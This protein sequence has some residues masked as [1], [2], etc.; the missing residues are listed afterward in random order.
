MR[1]VQGGGWRRAV[2][3]VCL[4]LLVVLAYG[5]ALHNGYVWDDRYF[6]TDY[7]TVSNYREAIEVAFAPLF[8]QGPYLRP[9]PLLMIYTEALASGFNP[10][11][12]HLANLLVHFVCSVLV[13]L[14]ALRASP[15]TRVSRTVHWV[16]LALAAAF[17]VHPALSEDVVWIS[18]RFDLLA[19]LF[20]LL[21][22]WVSARDELRDI[23]RALL[24]GALFLL[25]ALCKE[26][27]VVFP[28]LLAGYTLLRRASD[29]G[30][31]RIQLSAAFSRREWM[32]YAALLASGSLYLVLRASLMVG[33]S[34]PG[35][36][37]VTVEEQVVRV[38]LSLFKYAK[39]TFLPFVG[40]SPHHSFRWLE[41]S[42]W[43]Q[44]LLP[45]F[46]SV[47]MIALISGAAIQRRRP[48]W[49]LLVWLVAYLP[50]LHLLPLMIGGN[51]I[52][53]RFMYLPT[54]VLLALAP[55]AWNQVRLSIPA[56]RVVGV[57]V[58]LVLFGA[59][60]V[61]RSL[62]PVWAND[63]SLWRWTVAM[64][65][66][67][68]EAR[69]SLITAYVIRG[70]LPTAEAE[71]KTMVDA[72]MNTS[73]LVAIN[74][75]VAYYRK[76]YVDEAIAYY[77]KAY[78]YASTL[79]PFRASRLESNMATAYLI[80]GEGKLAADMVASA[81]RRDRENETALAQLILLCGESRIDQGMFRE[82][83]WTRALGMVEG[84]R[85]SILARREMKPLEGT[86]CPEADAVRPVSTA[87]SAEADM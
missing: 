61:C 6:L 85:A 80:K 69:E 67:S 70:D 47:L 52:Q 25:A 64:E 56:R 26:S 3:Y 7:S 68:V 36:P 5:G 16:P 38:G 20:M 58:P 15:A 79:R 53:Q 37:G 77:E 35:L 23:P 76:G 32:G 17:A 24:L 57:V 44:Y 73:A 63:L 31:A 51:I 12:S 83:D 82:G 4:G 39:L 65:P 27:A 11:V 48:G 50:V 13:Y 74:L 29:A 18:S 78:P 49:W 72:G 40:I 59:V 9:L 87:Q 60:L 33:A 75:G 19:T 62:T 71:L 86:V 66:A 1:A 42:S 28:V 45:L 10:A 21:G 46:V 54:A 30:A 8:Q 55:Y 43:D 22:L 2:P 14:I 84:L 81:L 41:S 34:L